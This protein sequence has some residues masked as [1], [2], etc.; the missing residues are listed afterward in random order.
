MCVAGVHVKNH[1]PD[2]TNQTT[3]VLLGDSR[4]KQWVGRYD[5]LIKRFG[6][7]MPRVTV[8]A[9][10][11]QFPLPM[12][13]PDRDVVGSTDG[14]ANKQYHDPRCSTAT[15]KCIQT[16][17]MKAADRTEFWTQVDAQ[18]NL[19]AIVVACEYVSGL[20]SLHW[21][22]SSNWNSAKGLV[23]WPR[24]HTEMA[25]RPYPADTIAIVEA[26]EA[27]I[28]KYV[29]LGVK[30]YMI[31]PDTWYESPK[32]DLE[33]GAGKKCHEPPLPH[34]NATYAGELRQCPW[35]GPQRIELAIRAHRN[36]MPPNLADYLRPRPAAEYHHTAGF[37]ADPLMEAATKAGAILLDAASTT[38]WGGMCPTVM[39]DGRVAYKDAGHL[40]H[41]FVEKFA[42]FLDETVG[43]D[44]GRPPQSE[45]C[46]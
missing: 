20:K 32:F 43:V 5:Y 16:W 24:T 21:G 42:S 28:R 27:R 33:D 45:Y 29:D 34:A 7:V 31:K 19:E 44:G 26:W 4:A 40:N 25:K 38:C 13:I 8:I 22:S 10:N 3:V 35:C 9:M 18:P 30:V 14:I 36:K 39:T 41:F 6:P 15:T 11:G 1:R 2:D 37:L 46:V 12:S 17:D 23:E